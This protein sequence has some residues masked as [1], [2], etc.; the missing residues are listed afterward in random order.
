MTRI[1]HPFS[2]RTFSARITSLVFSNTKI[3]QSTF[4]PFVTALSPFCLKKFKNAKVYCLD[5]NVILFK[6]I[7]ISFFLL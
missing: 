6:L 2:L 4:R 1:F 7:L 3:A 5:K